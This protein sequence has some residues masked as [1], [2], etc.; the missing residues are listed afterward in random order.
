MVDTGQNHLALR[1]ILANTIFMVH[2]GLI[3]N[4]FKVI[5]VGVAVA[6]LEYE[7][8]CCS[9]LDNISTVCVAPGFRP[10]PLRV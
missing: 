5:A 9:V 1:L 10:I 6:L 4:C 2:T 3:P 8:T 7:V